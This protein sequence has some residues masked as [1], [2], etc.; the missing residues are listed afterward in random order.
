MKDGVP[1]NRGH[2]LKQYYQNIKKDDV[3]MDVR[4]NVQ[5]CRE[6]GTDRKANDLAFN[7]NIVNRFSA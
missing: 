6:I 2:E 1:G 7:K 5:D 3:I 4:N